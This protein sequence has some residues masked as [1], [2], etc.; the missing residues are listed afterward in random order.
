MLENIP[1]AFP[2]QAI[3]AVYGDSMS[4]TQ[5]VAYLT[6]M[7]NKIITTI[8]ETI[9]GG[10]LPEVGV[11]DNGKIV[12]VINGAWELSSSMIETLG[13]L[14]ALESGLTDTNANVTVLQRQMASLLDDVV[15]LTATLLQINAGD[16]EPE[17]T[18]E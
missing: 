13:R 1:A 6:Y 15:E 14:D 7:I 18:E 11:G 17:D 16:V 12:E 2:N 4:Y 10:T 3:P 9:L 8:N 5:Q